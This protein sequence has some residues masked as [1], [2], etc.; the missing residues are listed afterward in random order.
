MEIPLC[1]A[2]RPQVEDIPLEDIDRAVQKM[3]RGQN[4]SGELL[5]V[6]RIERR[7]L[8]F[9]PCIALYYRSHACKD[10]QVAFYREDGYSIAH[11]NAFAVMG[12]PELIGASH[13]LQPPIGF[14]EEGLPSLGGRRVD[15]EELGTLERAIDA[16]SPSSAAS[17]G[18]ASTLSVD[19]EAQQK[20]EQAAAR[21][22]AM[23]QRPLRCH[24]HPKLLRDALTKSSE[25]LLIISP[26][27]THHVVDDMFIR[28][29]EAL[30][31]NDVQVFIG[32]G[33]ADEDGMKGNDKA[34][35]KTPISPQAE[36][37]LKQLNARFGNLMLKFVGNTHRKLL[38]T[39]SR[40]AVISSFNWLS[41]KGDPKYKA[42]DEYGYLV[43]EPIALEDIFKD[44]LTLM[45]EGYDHPSSSR[46]NSRRR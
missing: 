36:E 17:P 28:S 2:K 1:G 15:F 35:Q 7:E 32:Y 16:A 46:A 39:D 19:K 11:E 4:E 21:L 44:G 25:R 40:F 37:E 22:R 10:V 8:R 42:R 26:W 45:N 13:L 27:I 33:L 9:T 14:C 41:F 23:T 43:S 5:A 34:K 18:E 20:A 6:R 3:R 38:V 29:L 12:G 31:R 24:E 30:L